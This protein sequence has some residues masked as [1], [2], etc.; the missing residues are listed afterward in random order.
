MF[1][2]CNHKWKILSETTTESK[3]EQLGRLGVKVKIGK[4]HDGSAMEKKF[5]QIVTCSE[6]GKLKRFVERI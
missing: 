2:R 5:I 6:C 3:I 4:E 1:K